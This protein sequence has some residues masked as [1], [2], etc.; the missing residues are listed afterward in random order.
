MINKIKDIRV[1]NKKTTELGKKR[2]NLKKLICEY[3]SYQGKY[4]ISVENLVEYSILKKIDNLKSDI[5]TVNGTSFKLP[6]G[7]L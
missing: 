5:H 3:L 6:K 4:D 7:V 2:G 1:S